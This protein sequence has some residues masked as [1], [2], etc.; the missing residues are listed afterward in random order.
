V[1]RL[2]K[3]QEAESGPVYLVEVR[4]EAGGAL[5][6][7]AVAQSW[8]DAPQDISGYVNQGWHG[9]RRAEYGYPDA[10]GNWGVTFGPDGMQPP[11][12]GQSAFF[13]LSAD[14]PSDVLAR[15]A[16]LKDSRYRVLRPTFQ[17]VREIGGAPEYPTST[18]VSAARTSG[19]YRPP[20]WDTRLDPLGINV[21]PAQPAAGKPT[22]RLVAARYQDETQ[23][24]N[25]HHIYVE[26][27]DQ[28]G[29]RMVGQRVVLAWDD[30]Q[31]VMVTED[32]PA[33]EYA[34]NVPMYNY[35]GKYRVFVDGGASD[36]VNGLGLPGKRHVCYLLTFQKAK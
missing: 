21:T 29:R 12:Q 28:G 32:K 25:L 1:F 26:V 20:V 33:P 9:L 15:V 13:V 8:P 22:F 7:V 3:L 4:N 30:G 34:A 18:P 17:L 23:S 10:N 11:G 6:S 5:S 14:I 16:P 35:L 2:V 31:A 27:M 24:N 36:V 19:S